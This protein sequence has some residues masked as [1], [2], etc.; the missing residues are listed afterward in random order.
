MEN[1]I[2]DVEIRMSPVER[3]RCSPIN[4]MCGLT[5]T[6]VLLW[7]NLKL[8]TS[9]SLH[10]ATIVFKENYGIA[11]FHDMFWASNGDFELFTDNAAR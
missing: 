11:V 10:V 5:K 8:F 2:W 7:A 3:Y 6:Y 4:A 1:L 9:G